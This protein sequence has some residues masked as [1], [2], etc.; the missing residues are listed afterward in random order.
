MNLSN[1]IQNLNLKL[2][3][4]EIQN[5]NAILLNLNQNELK[6]ICLYTNATGEKCLEE[7]WWKEFYNK[8]SKKFPGFNIIEILPVENCSKLHFSIP[9]FYS[10][11]IREM[12]AVI[13]NSTLFISA[14]NGVMHLANSVG[15][16]TIGLFNKTNSVVFGPY[17]NFSGTFDTN[18]LNINEILN[19]IEI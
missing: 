15:V 5:G 12:G 8:L 4:E 14:D 9:S 2:S 7:M 19:G 1:Q 3:D 6:T 13:A 10:K 18:M 16:R 17:G 11:D